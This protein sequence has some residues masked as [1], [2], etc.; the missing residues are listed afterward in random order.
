MKRIL[1]SII[2]AFSLLAPLSAFE[3]GGLLD[4]N[5]KIICQNKT[6][7]FS[8]SNGIYLWGSTNLSESGNMYIKGEGMYKYTYLAPAKVL[9]Q[10]AD[11]DLLKFVGN[12]SKGKANINVAAGRFIISDL[13]GAIFAQNS[14]GAFVEY[15]APKFGIS[16][17]AGYTGLLNSNAV[18]ILDKNG[19]VFA[20]A[21]KVYALATP[22]IPLCFTLS[23]PSL[24]M[25][26][27]LSFQAN[28]FVD[29]TAEKYNRMYATANLTGPLAAKVFYNFVTDF[30]TENFK[31]ISNFTKLSVS[32]F[33]VSGLYVTGAFEYASG[34]NGALSAFRGFSS[35][36]AYSASRDF[37]TTGEIIPSVSVNYAPTRKILVGADVKSVFSCP[38]SKV[39]ATGLEADLNCIYN[40]FS[41][42]N[43]T[44]SLSGFKG[45]TDAN[46]DNFTANLKIA[47]AF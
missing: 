29:L 43:L 27:T 3:W 24:F 35:R 8:Q 14:D 42:L 47:V 30:G 7:A 36:A 5:S 10:V 39:T 16:A 11:L 41:D 17:Y 32:A 31:T 1:I 12:F 13:T 18:S 46:L 4:N 2:A 21:N 44:L 20:P 45:Y 40:V 23:L 19:N 38:D 34:N 15:A 33:P 6:T 26:Q 22:Y 9:T 28:A 37:Q 25:N